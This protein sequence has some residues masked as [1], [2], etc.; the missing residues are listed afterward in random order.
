VKENQPLRDYLPKVVLL[1]NDCEKGDGIALAKT[2]E[3]RM[4]PTFA[5]VNAG[6]EVTDRWAGYESVDGF[7][8]SVDTALADRRTIGE[9]KE[10]FAKAPSLSLSLALASYSETV[11]ANADAVTYYREAMK[12]DPQLV[13]EL[14][15]KAFMAMFY[16]L[17][18]KQFTP[19]DVVAAGQ[20]IAGDSAA[21]PGDHLTVASILKRVA[22]P[23]TYVPVLQRALKATAGA[24]DPDIVAGRKELEIDAALLIDKD[25][26]KALG[27]KRAM[28]PDGWR[29]DPSQLNDFAWWCCE[30][31][32][33]LEEAFDLAMKGAKLATANGD[34]A[35]LLDT[36][37][38]IVFK[39]GD[40]KK[41]IEL[42]E[43]AVQLMPDRKNFKQTLERF[44]GAPPK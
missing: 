23:E 13:G 33:N 27:L 14:R 44:K 20:E 25:P 40:A 32:V 22:P 41:A 38:E 39:Q 29:D 43:Q 16:G 12:Q 26:D 28:L 4:Y 9:K 30:S 34:K 2:Y 10:A 42:E 36:A 5:L 18:T 3:V 24:S 8:K 15:T 17:R 21:E 35:N 31:D 11:G 1:K 19:D 7:V 6:G 37:A